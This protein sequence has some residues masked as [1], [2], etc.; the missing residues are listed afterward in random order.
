MNYQI[1]ELILIKRNVQKLAKRV[2]NLGLESK[3]FVIC[4]IN[5]L[6]PFIVKFN[7]VE[8]KQMSYKTYTTRLISTGGGGGGV[9]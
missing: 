7:A 5:M 2:K 9:W 3:T 6:L 8:R 4:F 1:L